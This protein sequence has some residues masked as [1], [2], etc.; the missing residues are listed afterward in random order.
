VVRASYYDNEPAR[1]YH[2]ECSQHWRVY[3][4]DIPCYHDTFHTVLRQCLVSQLV[5]R[6]VIF[7]YAMFW[8]ETGK[9]LQFVDTDIFLWVWLRSWGCGS[10]P[11]GLGVGVR[12]WGCG[13][14]HIFLSRPIGV[15]LNLWA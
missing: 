12:L 11:V 10:G 15:R 3:I 2:C 13:G 1:G 14:A 7:F 8:K 9:E 4:A 5:R 6:L